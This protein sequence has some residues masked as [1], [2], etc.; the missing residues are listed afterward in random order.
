MY[1]IDVKQEGIN[2][3]LRNIIFIL[4]K[5]YIFN[6]S[7]GL[8]TVSAYQRAKVSALK[9]VNLGMRR[10][11]NITR[12]EVR[13]EIKEGATQPNAEPSSSLSPSRQKIKYTKKKQDQNL[14]RINNDQARL[15]MEQIEPIYPS[16]IVKI[17]Q[18]TRI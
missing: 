2:Q 5:H 15:S 11:N 12:K 18:K 13:D 9:I 3:F 1:Q 14:S 6:R 10:T 17:T 16:N 8:N 4:I 7:L